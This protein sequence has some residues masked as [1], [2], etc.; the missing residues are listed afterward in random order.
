MNIQRV[1]K[2]AIVL[3]TSTLGAWLGAALD[4]NNWL[5]LT[6]S[7]FGLIG[8]VVGLWLAYEIDNYINI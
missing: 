3:V 6:S 4:H 5:G 8:I 1:T 7:I 2:S